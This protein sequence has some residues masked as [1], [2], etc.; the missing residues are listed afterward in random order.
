MIENITNWGLYP[1][2]KSK[3]Y[4]PNSYKDIIDYVKS[5]DQLIARG[6]GRCY[7]DA[8]LANNIISTLNLNSIINF[9]N[10]SGII[11]VQSGI[12]LSTL[13]EYIIPFGFFLPVTPGTKFITVGGAFASDIHGKNHHIDGVFSD[14]V[15]EILILNEICQVLNIK[16]GEEMFYKTAGGMGLTGIILEVELKLKKI[17]TTYI[18]QKSIRAKNLN[19]IF[20]L[21]E[22]HKSYTY[23]VAWIDCLAKNKNLGRSVLLLG[24]HA[25]S[26]EITDK[27]IL[28]VHKKPF[29]NIP[30]YFPSIF[31]NA[32]IIKLFNFIFYNKSSSNTDK[33]FVHYDTFFYPLDKIN[34]WNRIYGKKGFIQYQ[35]VIPKENSFIGVSN[36]LKILSDNNLGSFLAVLK[37]FGK[38]HDNRYLEFPIEGYTLAID[39]KIDKKIWTILD[40]LDEI[41]TNLGGKIYLTKDARMSS[42]AFNIQYPNK[43]ELNRKFKSQQMIR[44]EQKFNKTFLI[45]GA[46]SD[47]AKAT[48]LQ[49]LKLYPDSLIILASRNVDEL[50]NFISNN[51]IQNNCII[52][53]YDVENFKSAKAFVKNLPAKPNLVLYAAGV[54]YNNDEYFEDL[55]KFEV[56]VNVNYTGAVTIINELV[57]D[58]NPYLKK[59]IGLSSIAGLKGRKSNYIYGSSKSGFHQYLFGLRQYLKNRN[60]CV[61]AITPG[62]V[63]TKMT[64]NVIKPGITVSADIVAKCILNNKKSFEIYPNIIWMA[65]GNLI[66][67]LPQKLISKI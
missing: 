43:F 6:N 53:F 9:D 18:Q 13:L 3:L 33:K 66:K 15:S 46:N 24:E 16:N 41:V 19:E 59:I 61:Q 34:N 58:N 47:I 35:F 60:I 7:G 38:S 31:L 55:S 50:N 57:S 37:L 54:F 63:D 56:S 42:K 4:S 40:H 48:V 14:H 25:L 5:T 65:I 32:Y 1:N 21:F 44:L 29:L 52:I 23:S 27:N 64:K 8:A 67:I 51:N 20:N 26:N 39:I 11:R 36:I 22:V 30:F 12:L 62:V 17:Q 45:I 49:Y 2:A 28:S 10:N